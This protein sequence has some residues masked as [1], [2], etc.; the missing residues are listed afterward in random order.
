MIMTVYHNR[1]KSKFPMVHLRPF[2]D[3]PFTV[4]SRHSFIAQND[5]HFP[6]MQNDFSES[7]FSYIRT[8]FQKLFT[9]L[10]PPI[11]HWI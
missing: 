10:L 2:Q 3:L 4:F 9:E 6:L 1:E 7:E 8:F 5:L 11:Q